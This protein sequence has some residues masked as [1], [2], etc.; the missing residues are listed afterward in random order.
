MCIYRYEEAVKAVS[1]TI[2]NRN[3]ALAINGGGNQNGSEN[4]EKLR[5]S[6]L[7]FVL[8]PRY[9]KSCRLPRDP[10]HSADFNS[11]ENTCIMQRLL[12]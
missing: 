5:L 12:Q 11:V 9:G 3:G 4:T 8:P 7:R 2:I 1:K 10:V 6:Q